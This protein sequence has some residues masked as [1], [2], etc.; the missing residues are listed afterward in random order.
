MKR[1]VEFTTTLIV[2]LE[3]QRDETTQTNR[4][5]STSGED[6]DCVGVG[7]RHIRNLKKIKEGSHGF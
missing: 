5:L 7:P 3:N 1:I 6:I 2:Y 4:V